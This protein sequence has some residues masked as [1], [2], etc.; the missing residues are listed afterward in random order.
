MKKLNIYKLIPLI[1]LVAVVWIN[2]SLLHKGLSGGWEKVAQLINQRDMRLVA[3]LILQ[4]ADECRQMD[5]KMLSSFINEK[6]AH[7]QRLMG[8]YPMSQDVWGRPYQITIG[9]ARII[10]RSSG[11]DKSFDSPDDAQFI[12][13][14][15]KSFD[16]ENPS[17]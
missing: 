12:L 10:I 9:P 14:I 3:L 1:A 15:R 17:P 5:G 11:P 7:T 2:A 4:N 16:T 13:P 8:L 6:L